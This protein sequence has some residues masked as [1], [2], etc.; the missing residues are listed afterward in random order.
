M[1]RVE[2]AAGVNQIGVAS[3]ELC[4][5][6][7]R[8]LGIT[9]ERSFAVVSRVLDLCMAVAAAT[10]DATAPV[11]A[12]R[13][14]PDGAAAAQAGTERVLKL[15][16]QWRGELNFLMATLSAG[17]G[18]DAARNPLQRLVLWLDMNGFYP[19]RVA[20]QQETSTQHGTGPA[21]STPLPVPGRV[22]LRQ[23]EV[24]RR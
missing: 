21:Q 16:R 20:A 9:H 12:L 17:E 1:L 24:A 2:A 4:H 8:G 18:D 10:A 22:A 15:M 6:V 14:T 13:R 19:R 3:S 7:M 23:A 11:A 5:T